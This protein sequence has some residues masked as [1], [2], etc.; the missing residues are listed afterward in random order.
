MPNFLEMILAQLKRADGRV[1]LREICEDRFVSVTGRELLDQIQ[2]VRT[3]IRSSGVQLGDRCVLL[4]PNSVRW[5]A[6][7]LA[8][9]AEGVIVVP[10]Y[11]RQAPAELVGMLKDCQPR[12]IFVG[13]AALGE[14]VA[15]AWPDAPRRVLFDDVLRQSAQQPRLPDA[16]NPRPDSD[17]VTIIYTSGTSGEPK[18]VCLNVGNLTHMLS[19][20]TERLDQ[21]MGATHE[22]E[23]VFH[24]LPFNFAASTILML[25]CLAR[26]SVLTLSTDLNKLADEIRLAAPNYFLNVPTLPERVRRGVEEAIAKRPAAIRSLFAKARSAWRRKHVGRGRALDAFW[27]ALGRALIFRKIR[28]RFGPHLRA[29]ICGSAPLAPETQQFFLMLGIPVLQAY[30]LTETTGICTLDDPRVPVEPGYVGTVISGIEMKLADNEEIVV[31]G[32][33]IF[34]GYWNRPEE[35]ARVLQDGWFH[36]GDQGEVNVRGNWRISGRIKNLI[37]LNSGH[38]IAPEP[39]EEK[40]ARLL[41][42]AQQVVVVG[43]GRG[44]LCALVTGEI[45]SAAVQAALDA[46]NPELPHYRQIR[47]FTIVREAFTPEI[48]LLTANGKLRRDAINARY[49]SEIKVMY[50]ATGNREAA[51]SSG[52]R[53]VIGGQQA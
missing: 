50:D 52:N 8:L 9:M 41:P 48:G 53:K 27:L 2:L 42:A 45:E 33:H 36:T 40:V 21:L 49:A 39:I 34:P 7:H 20:T 11:S 35:T 43:N 6:F 13:E 30:G 32:P 51:M 16:P 47:K 14:G 38:N 46:V 22:P 19:C 29:L 17:I 37:I 24:Y 5:A 15:Q 31:R 23:R 28:E 25:S 3:F 1:V 4:A 44:Y 26:E 12:L 18:G 10:L